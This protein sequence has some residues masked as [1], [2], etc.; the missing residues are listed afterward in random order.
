[1]YLGKVIGCVTA[2]AKDSRLRG[3]RLLVVQPI[4]PDLKPNGK[5]LICT[6]STGAG[7]GE[8]VYWVRGKEAAMPFRPD[9]VPTDTT[10]VGIVD[11][12]NLK[13]S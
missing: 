6:D 1:M 3:H 7:A 8:V 13:G 10:I 5:T 12:L 9:E 11:Q 4:T 2:T